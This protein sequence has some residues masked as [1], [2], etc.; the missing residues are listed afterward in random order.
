MINNDNRAK[1]VNLVIDKTSTIKLT[2]DTY[3]TKLTDKD[4]SYS[5]I[6]FN[7]YKLYVNGKSI[8]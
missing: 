1:K 8:N 2:G 6:D 3:V 4:T 5:N 7:G